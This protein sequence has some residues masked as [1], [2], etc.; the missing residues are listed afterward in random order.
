MRERVAALEAQI[1][2]LLMP[3]I[4]IMSP[5]DAATSSSR[6]QSVACRTRWQ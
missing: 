3:A 1:K 5:L 4:V 6:S 2:N